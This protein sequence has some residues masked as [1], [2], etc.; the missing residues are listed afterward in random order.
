VDVPDDF[1]TACS[2]RLAFDTSGLSQS[3]VPLD[4]HLGSFVGN[5]TLA[6]GG[7]GSSPGNDHIAVLRMFQRERIRIGIA[8]LRTIFAVAG[9]IPRR[10]GP[11]L[12]ASRD[13]RESVD[14]TG[15]ARPRSLSVHWR[16]MP[17]AILKPITFSN[18]DIHELWDEA[19]GVR[20]VSAA[21]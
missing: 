9:H 20:V 18:I 21:R 8:G 14:F 11:L 4:I 7:D 1:E 2:V 19:A 6:I 15:G 13:L 16:R 10:R 5:L 3:A 17:A 12:K